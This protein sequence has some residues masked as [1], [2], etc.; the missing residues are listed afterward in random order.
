MPA[1]LKVAVVLSALALAKVT[2]PG[3]LTLLHD[4][5]TV[6]PAGLPSSDT[7]PLSEALA[8]RVIVWSAPALTTGARLAAS[9]VTVTSSLAFS[10]ESSAV[11]RSR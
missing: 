7:L 5:V 9:T 4:E 11:S 1:M 10:S 6:A 8:G 2:V 3:P